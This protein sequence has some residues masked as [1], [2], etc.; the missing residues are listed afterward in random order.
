MT[1][2][3]HIDACFVIMHIKNVLSKQIGCFGAESVGE[4]V[5]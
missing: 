3:A 5:F 1:E 2:R 4:W